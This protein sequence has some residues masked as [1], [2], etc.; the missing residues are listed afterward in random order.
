MVATRPGG[1]GIK[2]YLGGIALAMMGWG[3][4]RIRVA[5]DAKGRLGRAQKPTGKDPDVK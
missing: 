1:L 5:R 3:I 2:L 4:Q